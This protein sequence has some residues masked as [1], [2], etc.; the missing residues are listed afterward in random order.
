VLCATI[1][2]K[3]TCSRNA[4]TEIDTNLVF[5]SLYKQIQKASL[6]SSSG[7]HILATAPTL[8]VTLCESEL[9]CRLWV[10]NIHVVL[11]QTFRQSVTVTVGETDGVRVRVDFRCFTASCHTIRQRILTRTSSYTDSRHQTQCIHS[12]TQSVSQAI[13]QSSVRNWL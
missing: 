12:F 4:A 1:L 8:S 5:S 13:N 9:P 10:Y 3:C 11:R 7:A 2:C 6:N